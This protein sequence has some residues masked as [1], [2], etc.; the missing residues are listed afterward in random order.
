MIII[1]VTTLLL[2]FDQCSNFVYNIIYSSI[3]GMSI[4]SIQ[5][6]ILAKNL[7]LKSIHNVITTLN[8]MPNPSSTIDMQ[9]ASQ[10]NSEE[11]KYKYPLLQLLLSIGIWN[12]M[13]ITMIYIIAS[14]CL[15]TQDEIRSN[16]ARYTYIPRHRRWNRINWLK[17]KASIAMRKISH[18]LE[19]H[20]S[21]YNKSFE[22]RM[23]N[24]Q[25]QKIAS[26]YNHYVHKSAT[27]TTAITAMAALIAM[28]AS[29]TPIYANATTFD[30]DSKAVGIDNRCSACISHDIRD[31][32]GPLHDSNRTIKGFGGVTHRSTIMS[33]TIKWKWEDDKG[34][35]HKHLIP[36]SYFVPDGKARLLSP[37]H[38]AKTQRGKLRQS[39]GEFTNSKECKLQWGTNGEY[40][41]TVPLTT[42][43]N[44]ATFYLAPGYKDYDA[45]CQEAKISPNE[46]DNPSLNPIEHK[47]EEGEYVAPATEPPSNKE[48]WNTSL[49]STAKR[50]FDI[51]GPE[52]GI[53]KIVN[54]NRKPIDDMS[55]DTRE[56]LSLHYRM[57]HI[58]FPKLQLMAKQGKLKSSLARCAIPVCPACQ[59]AKQTR[60]PWRQKPTK[61]RIT[62]TDQLQPGEIVSVDQMVSPTPGLVAQMT[63]ALTNRRYKYATVYVDQASRLSY[64]YLQKTASAEETIK[65]KIAFELFARSQGVSIKGYHADNGIFRANAWMNHC[66]KYNQRLTYAG[67]N[68]H[69]QNGIAER[70]IRELQ[71]MART[72]FIHAAKRWSNCITANLWPYAIR[73]AS[74]AINNTPSMQNKQRRTPIEIFTQTKVAS[75]PKHFHAFGCPAYVLE[76]ELQL[77]K[78][79]HKWKQRTEVGIYLGQSPIHSKNIALILNRKTGLVSPQYHVKCDS[80][81]HSVLNTKFE[82]QWQQKAGFKM[83]PSPHEQNKIKES[84]EPRDKISQN[85]NKTLHSEG[86]NRYS[87]K[88]KDRSTMDQH[89]LEK[90]SRQKLQHKSTSK[91]SVTNKR[92]RLKPS[93]TRRQTKVGLK[94]HEGSAAMANAAVLGVT[95]KVVHQPDLIEVLATEISRN[96]S[97][98][99]EGEILC[100][101]AIFPDYHQQ[102][103]D[104]MIQ[105]DPI[106]AMKAT[107][108]PD[109]MYMH[110]AMRE[111]DW[112]QFRMAMQK[113]VQDQMDNG[114]FTIVKRSQIPKGKIILPAV[115][116][117]K[118]KRDIKT[119][120]IKKYKA[121]LNLDG[122]R[123]RK[124][125]HYDQTYAPVTSWKFIRLL[126]IMIIMH[127]WYSKQIDYVLAFPQAP[128]EREL[129]MQIPKGFEIEGNKNNE[130]VLKV[131]RNVYGQCQASRVWFQYLRNKLIKELKFK[132]SKI[133]ECVFY[134]GKTIYMLYT[135]DSI[136]AGPCQKE[137][138]QVVKD[139]Q[140]AN[141][142]V[143]DEGDVQDFLGVNIKK[144]DDGNIQLSQPHL[145]D[146]ILKDLNMTQDNVKTKSTPAM[147]SKLLT[148][149]ED[150]EEF[151][152]SF[153]YRSIIGKL[154]Y[155]EKGTRS[156]ISY[157]THQCARFA[158]KPKAS[159]AKAVRWLARYLK[160]TRDKGLL[161]KPSPNHGLEV[162]VDAD[163]SGNWDPK[164]PEKDKD[165]AR[166]RHGYIITYEKCP[167][168][169]KSQMQ[170]EVCLSSTESEYVGLS[171]ALREVIP[172][173]EIIKEM[174][175]LKLI[176]T[177]TC[178]KVHCRVFEDNSGALEMA[179]VHKYRPR[180]KHLNVKYHHFRDYVERDEISIHKIDTKDQLADYLTKPVTQEILEHLR[181]QVM[182]W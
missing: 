35:I 59:Y 94:T 26:K 139:L 104:I 5:E 23:K 156:D 102:H 89:T 41:L 87:T 173:M 164:S 28:S 60:K 18:N 103:E 12:I 92:N 178:P 153:H 172:I 168:I 80:M 181:P 141:L 15:E 14:I 69:H 159:H 19:S 152:E 162:F 20:I 16:D 93:A 63:G 1:I 134:R 39:T 127:G 32:I 147:V 140:K 121:R 136:L 84:G 110:E 115:W 157:I 22:H 48:V 182:G 9:H 86:V 107:A 67:V 138:D 33:G 105:D 95:P 6:I 83:K 109:T 47:D 38:W 133:D 53:D 130:Y 179:K 143:T 43:S 117:M 129:Y 97:H 106:L 70:R 149:D 21:R 77:S 17:N 78:P 55:N 50:D 81:F 96:T 40:T 132:Q 116:Q 36:N 44:V 108:D 68:A 75:N 72:M 11:V 56:L 24:K 54:S 111:P 79:F 2:D 71:S 180:T 25:R 124:G 74:N 49:H 166:S 13:L 90:H 99:V 76:N 167:V 174:K 118:R 171:Y 46:D 119:R 101:E 128:I 3:L 65:G 98:D 37:Q 100:L 42:D 170:T 61:S 148:R 144:L 114:N 29:P 163:F 146:Q 125:I 122:S 30:T 135:D 175:Q 31:F 151:D 10:N 66:H 150:G 58:P 52:L 123:Q 155:L 7:C 169:W 176:S 131:N 27:R 137:I 160:A 73:H 113:E 51:N 142:N 91:S 85:R 161:I 82:S 177:S 45:Y 120:K 112:D 64:T 145:V 62:K 88:R 154:H 57:G 126:L 34:C 158:D 8:K 4:N 165:T